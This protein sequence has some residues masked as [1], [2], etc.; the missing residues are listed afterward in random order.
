[1][2]NNKI[3]L[4]NRLG[5]TL[6]CSRKDVIDRLDKCDQETLVRLFG[7]FW[8]KTQGTFARSMQIDSAGFSRWINLKKIVDVYTKAVVD[9]LFDIYDG[10]DYDLPPKNHYL[11]NT[12]WDKFKQDLLRRQEVQLVIFLNACSNLGELNDIYHIIKNIEQPSIHVV[13]FTSSGIEIDF[14]NRKWKWCSWIRTPCYDTHTISILESMA[15]RDLHETELFVTNGIPRLKFM[16]VSIDDFAYTL[17]FI[18]KKLIIPRVAVY[19]KTGLINISMIILFYMI[20]FNLDM[21]VEQNAVILL[22]YISKRMD[23]LVI[24]NCDN[25]NIL[26]D[27]YCQL[28]D[29][30][31]LRRAFF[32]NLEILDEIIIS[33]LSLNTNLRKSV[34]RKAE[35]ELCNVKELCELKKLLETRSSLSLS[36]LGT[37]L[38]ISQELITVTGKRKWLDVLNDISIQQFLGCRLERTIKDN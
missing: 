3:L 15:I 25:E 7:L 23:S 4:L 17:V 27:K 22:D 26:I 21:R 16:I 37:L 2:A 6:E 14:W 33:E 13:L 30:P 24:G 35:L 5:L 12:E 1:M 11:Y 38:T 8:K 36:E 10:E 18:L 19:F 32:N 9:F 28:A 34:K 20:K 31:T 29:I